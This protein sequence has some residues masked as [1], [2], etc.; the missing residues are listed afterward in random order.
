MK[1][2]FKQIHYSLFHLLVAAI[3]TAAFAIPSE[4]EAKKK[5]KTPPGQSDKGGSSGGSSGSSGSNGGGK[6]GGQVIGVAGASTPERYYFAN[7]VGV[8]GTMSIVGPVVIVAD[9]D[10]NIG[11]NTVTIEPGGSLELY[12][13]GDITVNGKGGFNNTNVPASLIVY[14]TADEQTGQAIVLS[15][16]GYLSAVLYAPNALYRTNGGGNKGATLGSVVAKDIRFNGS[17]GPFHYD[18]SLADLMVNAGMRVTQYRSLEPG[19]K[20]PSS[21]GRTLIGNNNYDALFSQVFNGQNQNP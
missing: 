5:D 2:L 15:G 7:D 16:N 17:P 4:L 13:E 19:D 10:F 21:A 11:N 9:G 18:E 12:V 3:I 20:T 8:S 1:H 6:K 14:G